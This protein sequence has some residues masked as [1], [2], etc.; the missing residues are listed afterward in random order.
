MSNYTSKKTPTD[1]AT[2]IASM[3]PLSLDTIDDDINQYVATTHQMSQE[4]YTDLDNTN[5]AKNTS[6]IEQPPSIHSSQ[7]LRTNKNWKTFY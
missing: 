4:L 3:V 6:C 1:E 2:S 7:S 5:P